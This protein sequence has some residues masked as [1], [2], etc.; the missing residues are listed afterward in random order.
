MKPMYKVIQGETI[1]ASFAFFSEA[2]AF[3]RVDQKIYSLI[4]G[5]DGCWLVDPAYDPSK[6]PVN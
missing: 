3:A 2:W 6:T 1:V 4:L 5:P